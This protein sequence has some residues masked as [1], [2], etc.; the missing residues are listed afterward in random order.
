MRIFIPGSFCL[1]TVGAKDCG[2]VPPP[3]AFP[4]RGPVTVTLVSVARGQQK[5]LWKGNPGLHRGP[6]A[7][8]KDE[9]TKPNT[10]KLLWNIFQGTEHFESPTWEQAQHNDALHGADACQAFQRP[11]H[12]GLRGWPR[13]PAR[14]WHRLRRARL[15]PRVLAQKRP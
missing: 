14:A 12:A 2:V 13:P 1:V 11:P 4:L 15:P 5:C 8:V 9:K 10:V 6:T 3:P 7:F